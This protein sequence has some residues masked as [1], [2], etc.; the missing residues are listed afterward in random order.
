[1]AIRLNTNVIKRALK[2]IKEGM[3]DAADFSER[4][5][6][7]I[8]PNDEVSRSAHAADRRDFGNLFGFCAEL[9]ERAGKL[10]R[11]PWWSLTLDVSTIP[12]DYEGFK[13]KLWDAV[14]SV[15]FYFLDHDIDIGQLDGKERRRYIMNACADATSGAE[16]GIYAK[17]GFREQEGVK[18]DIEKESDRS[19]QENYEA[20]FV[21]LC[22]CD[23][24]FGKKPVQQVK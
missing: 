17:A 2:D 19:A 4:E 23:E 14:V 5:L 16:I 22:I 7:Q 24:I 18:I 11:F 10:R 6:A 1:M 8:H 15:G 3:S 20:H 13:D 21:L 12:A 9:N